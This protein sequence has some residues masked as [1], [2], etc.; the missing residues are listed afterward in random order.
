MMGG[1]EEGAGGTDNPK[2]MSVFEKIREDL[3]NFDNEDLLSFLSLL[4][5][6]EKGGL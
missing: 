6:P 2:A 4:P 3:D 5:T 1:L